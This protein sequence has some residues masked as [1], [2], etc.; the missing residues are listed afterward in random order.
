MNCKKITGTQWLTRFSILL[1]IE[2]IFC[3]T[4]LGQIPIG[5]IVATL[6]A[7]PIVITAMVLG[8]RAGALMGFFAGLFAFLV[9]TFTPPNPFVAFVFTPFYPYAGMQGNFAS[10]LICFVP[11]ILVGVVAG[12]VCKA[13]TRKAPRADLLRFG[14]AGA[15]GSLTNTVLVLGGIWLFFGDAYAGILAG[16][17]APGQA[18]VWGGVINA[19]VMGSFLTNGIPEAVVAFVAGYG[20]CKLLERAFA[21]GG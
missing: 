16:A 15:L 12:L 5:P 14:V 7:V 9:W 6:A 20:V 3:F 1:A 13:V 2:A 21:R 4:P 19:I 10:V 8:V 18:A 11:R 17:V